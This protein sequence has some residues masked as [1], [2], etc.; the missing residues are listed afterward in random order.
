MF[1]DSNY[2]QKQDNTNKWL[3]DIVLFPLQLSL[4][5]GTYLEQ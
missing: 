4:H 5:N 2:E 3:T 1:D